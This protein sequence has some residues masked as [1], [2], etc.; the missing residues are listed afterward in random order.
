MRRNDEE[1]WINEK[2]KFNFRIMN[3]RSW[4]KTDWKKYLLNRIKH[5]RFI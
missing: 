5:K 3:G 1:N 2:R 4:K